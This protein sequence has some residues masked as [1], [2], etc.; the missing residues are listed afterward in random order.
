MIKRLCL[1]CLIGAVAACSSNP[2][3]HKPMP[4]QPLPVK[5]QQIQFKKQAVLRIGKGFKQGEVTLHLATQNDKI[6]AASY[7]GVIAALDSQAQ[8]VWQQ[9][10][11][12]M[13]TGG[14][15][16]AYG[17]VIVA[18]AQ[19]EVL[20]LDAHTGAIQWQKAVLTPILA[21]AAQSAQRVI[22]QSSDGKVYGLDAKTGNTIW[23]FDVPVAAL[24]VR[25]YASPMIIG[26]NVIVAGELGKI[27]ALDAQ[28]GIGQWE[29]RVTTPEGRSE[30]ERMVDI[31]SNMLVSDNT[32]YVASYQGHMAAID[33][34]DKPHI[35]WQVPLSSYQA[36]A[37]NDTLIFAVDT[38]SHVIALDKK[39]GI[40]V[41][42]Q[43]NLAWRGVSRPINIGNY[44]LVGDN[45]GYVHI[46]AQDSGT[47][48]G[49]FAVNGAVVDMAVLNQ[50]VWVYTQKGQ[51]SAF[52]LAP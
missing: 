40:T 36:L 31:D 7:D 8:R 18:T 32:L 29:S 4:L 5:Q 23:V 3:M 22:V 10:M 43:Q 15:N 27:T 12:Y 52:S 33:I 34:Q 13:M 24:N 50:Q 14:V 9:K 28:T 30:L 16:A 46:L 6:Y 1:V 20:A 48:L 2:K 44:V 35:K 17:R 45:K 26:D 37:Q 41:W 39:T 51:L 47:L 21:A 42:K 38:S 11:P 49:R 19:G 25:G